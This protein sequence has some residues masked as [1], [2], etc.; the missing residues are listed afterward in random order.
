MITC[1]GFFLRCVASIRVT[2]DDLSKLGPSMS[3]LPCVLRLQLTH[4]HPLDSADALRQLKVSTATKEQF[5][6]YFEDGE[7]KKLVM[8]LRYR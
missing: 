1:S 6:L 7:D 3:S 4:N 5:V 8:S 2:F